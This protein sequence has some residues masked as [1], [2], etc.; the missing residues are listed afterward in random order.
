MLKMKIVALAFA[1]LAASSA[2]AA[3]RVV[4]LEDFTN[5][6]C[7]PCWAVEDSV[8][9]FVNR[10][11]PNGNLA[12][13]RCHVNW[14]SAGD[15]IYTANPTEQNIRKAQYGVSG[16]P[17][18][19]FD[20]VVNGSGSNLQPG[21]N[22]RVSVPAILDI[23]VARNGDET[24]GTIS[25]MLIAE[26]DPLWTVPMMVWPI[27]VEDN[28]PGAGYWSGSVFEQAFRDN[29][30]GYYGEEISFTG[31]YPDTIY[32]D[33]DYQVDPKW[34]ADELYLA[35]FVQC[36]YQYQL[37][38]VENAHWAKF[39]DLETGIENGGWNGWT[40]PVLSVGPNPSPG[41]FAVN[42]MVPGSGNG[43]IEVYS[44]AGRVVAS[45][46]VND[47][48]TVT[49]DESGIYIVRLSTD[50]GLWVTESVAVIR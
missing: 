8:N 41:T 1:L 4:L 18:F 28:V 11:L 32:V 21:F 14:P 13:I 49:V 34:V 17:Y 33:A 30:L 47:L 6:G 9:S 44:L 35:T 27:L 29:L 40:Q 26:E 19:K 50:E 46:A 36:G 31:P 15:P 12:V 42:A 2:L 10:N 23:E 22:N 38:E 39:L 3:D 5:S 24:S 16:V 43:S 7:G 48:K 20:G 45:G 37:H 25:I